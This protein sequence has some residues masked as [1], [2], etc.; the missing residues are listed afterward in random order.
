MKS[1]L[2]TGGAGFIGSHT[3]LELIYKGY[4]LVLIDNFDN[5]SAESIERIKYISSL[6]NINVKDNF[7]F[8]FGDIKDENFL[9][10][11]FNKSKINNKEIKGVMHFAGVKSVSES[12][13][14]PIK[15]WD[16]NLKGTISLLT[17]MN[18]FNCRNLVFSSSATIYGLKNQSPLSEN[19]SC[20]PVNPYGETKITIE[21]MLKNIYDSD[22]KSWNILNLRYFNPIGAHSSGMIG[23]ISKAESENLFPVL[24]EVASNKREE[25][26]IY[27][28]DWPTKDGTCIRDYIHVSDIANGHLK[29]IEFLLSSKGVFYSINLGTGI[30]TSVLELLKIF[31]KVNKVK[32]DFTYSNRRKGDVPILCADVGF[33][34]KILGWNASRNIEEMCIDGWKWYLYRKKY[35]NK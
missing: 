6:D 28:N 1:I 22:P 15:Y 18:K 27:G 25:L 32:I 19:K 4:R 14:N 31:E 8:N 35:S 21:K 24:C 3:S 33:A 23:E 5:S 26:Q 10:Y 30:P 9:E 12:V 17:I 2:V 16:Q 11:V 13:K 29:A 20:F 34:K 7:E